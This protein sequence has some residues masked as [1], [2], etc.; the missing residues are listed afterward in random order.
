VVHKSD[1]GIDD[2]KFPFEEN[3]TT[4]TTRDAA[5]TTEFDVY[6]RSAVIDET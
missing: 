3:I 4:K 5:T 2:I 6:S 1:N